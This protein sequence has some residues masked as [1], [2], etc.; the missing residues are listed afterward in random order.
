MRMHFLQGCFLED[1]IF[2]CFF[3]ISYPSKHAD[4]IVIYEK[5]SLRACMLCLL[6]DNLCKSFRER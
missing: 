2:G 4:I 3:V 6:L 1:L 5:S